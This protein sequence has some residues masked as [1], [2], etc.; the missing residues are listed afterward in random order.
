[1]NEPSQEE[2]LGILDVPTHVHP[3]LEPVNDEDDDDDVVEEELVQSQPVADVVT[4]NLSWFK[5]F[6][7]E[8]DIN[9][10]VD[11]IDW[12]FRGVD[13]AMWSEGDDEDLKRAYIDYFMTCFPPLAMRLIITETNKKLVEKNADEID[14]G[15]F[16]K[17][18]GVMILITRFEFGERRDCFQSKQTC[19]YMPAPNISAATG[20]TRH[21]FDMIWSC[22]T[23]SK[24]PAARP[25]GMSSAEYR[26]KHVDDFVDGF[27]GHRRAAFTPS[28]RICI[29]ES[30]SRWYGNGGEWINE[31]LPHY[32]AMERK[33]CLSDCCCSSTHH[34][35][36][37][38]KM[39]VRYRMQLV[40]KQV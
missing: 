27:N 29:D 14:L 40:V 13:G 9:G 15:E 25:E 31:G 8:E 1:V 10:P 7:P 2:A 18:V 21:R 22:L 38:L 24:V 39:A 4:D 28:E 33:V 5:E 34:L 16:L 32:I 17:F 3:V 19:P 37:S 30:M 35:P 12:K 6:D 11:P 23:F 20:M 36:T 26:W